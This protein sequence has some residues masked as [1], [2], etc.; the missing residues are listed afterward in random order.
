MESN[1]LLARQ[2]VSSIPQPNGY[3]CHD[4]NLQPKSLRP[5]LRWK[6]QALNFGGI[7]YCVI[8]TLLSFIVGIKITLPDVY[9][10]DKNILFNRQCLAV[11]FFSILVANYVFMLLKSKDSIVGQSTASLPLFDPQLHQWKYCDTCRLHTPP[12]AKHCPICNHCV[13]KRD[14][15]CFF[16]GCCIGFHNQ[17]YFT[18]FCFYVCLA[19]IYSIYVTAAYLQVHYASF[20][21]SEF[22]AY[23]LP[24]V[25]LRW[26]SGTVGIGTAALVFHCYFSCVTF[27]ASFY[28]FVWQCLL[29]WSGQSTYEFFKG[30]R[31]YAHPLSENLKS[32]FGHAWWLNFLIPCPWIKNKGNGIDWI[33]S[34]EEKD[35]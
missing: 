15:H 13:L 19:A 16:A 14:H 18:V 26:I 33:L 10:F 20:F 31:L 1:L 35:K 12:R 9:S 3:H 17:R 34:H 11:C 27:S 30:I 7:A 4:L 24:W 22:Y 21:S 5:T 32:M 2:V 25:C 23:L 29:T 6:L 8:Y 28:F